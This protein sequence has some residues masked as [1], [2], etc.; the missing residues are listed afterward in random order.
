MT[1]EPPVNRLLTVMGACGE[2]AFVQLAMTPT[3]AFFEQL[4]QAPV[5]AP[6]GAPVA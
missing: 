6:R 3:P 2:P 1:R 5:Q 4:R